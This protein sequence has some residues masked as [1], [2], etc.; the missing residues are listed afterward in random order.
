MTAPKIQEKFVAPEQKLHDALFPK[1][2]E[3]RKYG[4]DPDGEA[5]EAAPA[6]DLNMPRDWLESDP[7]ATQAA[8]AGFVAA[9]ATNDM[10]KSI[11]ADF[12]RHAENP[13]TA[14]EADVDADLQRIYGDKAQEKLGLARK[15]VAQTAKT[16]PKVY[17][18]LNAHGTGNDINVILKVIARAEGL[19]RKGKL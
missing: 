13:V 5:L 9:G 7:E 2:A 11:T 4:F 18:Y 1:D 15:L 16:W 17:D 12:M 8:R 10:V 3:I 19:Q 6:V 14:T